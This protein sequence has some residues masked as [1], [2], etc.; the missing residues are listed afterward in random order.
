[1]EWSHLRILPSIHN[2]GTPVLS[3]T[4]R[5]RNFRENQKRMALNNKHNMEQEDNDKRLRKEHEKRL[6]KERKKRYYEKKKQNSNTRS[7]AKKKK[8]RSVG[9]YQI[10][11]TETT[12]RT[13]TTERKLRSKPSSSTSK[14]LDPTSHAS[15]DVNAAKI[16]ESFR[17]EELI[18]ESDEVSSA[19]GQSLSLRNIDE[20]LLLPLHDT[21]LGTAIVLSEVN[22]AMNTFL[23]GFTLYNTEVRRN[24]NTRE[25]AVASEPRPRHLNDSELR[26]HTGLMKRAGVSENNVTKTVVDES[27]SILASASEGGPWKEEDE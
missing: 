22:A 18:T 20:D 9:K 24:K 27:A 12:D 15:D 23:S 21:D 11:V 26:S 3:G 6:G 10:H 16:L 2:L 5:R 14:K 25:I 7:A 4:E 17:K 19:S 8:A 1:M 13:P